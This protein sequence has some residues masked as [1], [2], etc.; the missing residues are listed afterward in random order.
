MLYVK[1]FPMFVEG[2]G[3]D[4]YESGHNKNHIRGD[5]SDFMLEE[6][7]E[8]PEDQDIEAID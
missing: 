5:F 4:A 7:F 8:D 3:G 2:E 1:Y 6:M